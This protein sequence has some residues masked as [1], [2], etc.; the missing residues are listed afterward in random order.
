MSQ[1]DQGTAS[2][3]HQAAPS[4]LAASSSRGRGSRPGRKHG[5]RHHQLPVRLKPPA[6]VLY[7]EAAEDIPHSWEDDNFSDW[8]GCGEDGCCVNTSWWTGVLKEHL[9]EKEGL[10]HRTIDGTNVTS[11]FQDVIRDPLVFQSTD[12]AR[13]F[14]ETYE[15]KGA[16]A[17]CLECIAYQY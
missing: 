5:W 1:N 3:A 8:Y 16:F 14:F 2:R 11:C 10:I 4:H 17:T 12:E 13:A 6:R 9:V 7:D 15:L